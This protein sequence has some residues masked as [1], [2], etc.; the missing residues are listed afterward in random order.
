[1]SRAGHSTKTEPVMEILL[2]VVG[3]SLSLIVPFLFQPRTMCAVGAFAGIEP[4][5]Q[6]GCE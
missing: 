5:T 3:A 2:L 4:A 1:M 6:E